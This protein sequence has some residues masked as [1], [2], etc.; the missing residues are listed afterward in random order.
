L[1]PAK[2][3]LSVDQDQRR[4]E[5]DGHGEGDDADPSRGVEGRAGEE[6]LHHQRRHSDQATVDHSKLVKAFLLRLPGEQLGGDSFRFCDRL[7][8]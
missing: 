2:D 5:G 4:E 1:T 6:R 3:L 7:L 8:S